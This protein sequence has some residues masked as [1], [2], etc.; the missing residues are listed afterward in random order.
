M[1]TARDLRAT[2]IGGGWILAASPG[3]P[4]LLRAPSKRASTLSWTGRTPPGA[5]QLPRPDRTSL[6][7]PPPNGPRRTGVRC[8]P[9]AVRCPDRH[10]W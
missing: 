4:S 10:R 7:M 1:Q 8:A 9:L 2:A 5:R 6:G 3:S